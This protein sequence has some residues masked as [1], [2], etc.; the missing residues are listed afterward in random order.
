MYRTPEQYTTVVHSTCGARME[1]AKCQGKDV[2]GAK[3]CV[4]MDC[5]C[6]RQRA[7]T[8]ARDVD[9]AAAMLVVGAHSYTNG[10]ERHPAYRYPG[11]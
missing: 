1:P 4:N 7:P 9:G 2:P 5:A 11:Q 3:V 6:R 10:G 8:V